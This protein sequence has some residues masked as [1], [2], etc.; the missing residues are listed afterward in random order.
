MSNKVMGVILI[1]SGLASGYA[2]IFNEWVIEGQGLIA[3]L[4][5]FLT[6]GCLSG[7]IVLFTERD[8]AFDR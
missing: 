6:L 2:W 1:I 5:C 3:V 8:D 7:G 4:L